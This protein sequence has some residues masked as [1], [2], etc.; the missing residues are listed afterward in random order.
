MCAWCVLRSHQVVID[1]TK[2]ETELWLW[3]RKLDICGNSK[4]FRGV[5]GCK[6]TQNVAD[7]IDIR[8]DIDCDKI[9]QLNLILEINYRQ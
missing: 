4:N 9:E 3:R 5:N 7:N 1:M 8:N 6:T 2:I